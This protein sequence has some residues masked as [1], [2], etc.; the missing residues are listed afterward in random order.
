MHTLFDYDDEVTDLN[1]KIM[2]KFRR[3]YFESIANKIT[4]F[5]TLFT[6]G[7]SNIM[8]FININFD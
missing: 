4:K 6:G 1:M 7:C 5:V 3:E 2:W 8:D